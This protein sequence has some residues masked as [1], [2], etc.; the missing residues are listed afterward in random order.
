MSER[1]NANRSIFVA[2]AAGA[3]GRQLLPMLIGTGYK[4]FGTTRKPGKTVSNAGDGSTRFLVDVFHRN[5]LIGAV[6]RGETG[7]DHPP[8]HR[9]LGGGFRGE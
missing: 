2:G 6:G 8:A 5:S 3:I 7:C 9:S 4:V 1:S